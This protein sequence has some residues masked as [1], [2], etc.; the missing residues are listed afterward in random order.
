M[1]VDN[2][3]ALRYLYIAHQTPIDSIEVISKLIDI[4]GCNKVVMVENESGNA[5][6]LHYACTQ[7]MFS[8]ELGTKLIETG[9]REGLVIH[10]DY[11]EYTLLF[12]TPSTQTTQ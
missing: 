11:N 4:G 7:L 1:D 3:T 12:T 5:T 10:K 9:R 6:A 2:D 8:A